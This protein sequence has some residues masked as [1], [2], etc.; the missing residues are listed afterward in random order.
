MRLRELTIFQREKKNKVD[1]H[2]EGKMNEPK[3]KVNEHEYDQL[4]TCI[5]K[6]YF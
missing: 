4:T 1:K 3:Y 2:F 6:C 5:R